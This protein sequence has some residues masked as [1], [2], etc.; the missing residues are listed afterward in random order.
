MNPLDMAMTVLKASVQRRVSQDTPGWAT[1]LIHEEGQDP[2]V[3]WS[4]TAHPSISD[5]RLHGAQ[6][7]AGYAPV[8]E[9]SST[10][11]RKPTATTD[12]DS[13]DMASDFQSKTRNPAKNSLLTRLKQIPKRA[14]QD[15][16]VQERNRM[17]WADANRQNQQA[18][19]QGT[20]QPVPQP[21]PLQQPVPQP[22]PLQQ[23]VPQPQGMVNQP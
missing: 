5:E 8:I 7:S 1:Q 21:P 16:Q 12:D 17:S 2:D 13:Y 20:M 4:K 19:A 9:S 11:I 6:L 10:G 18:L 3:K 23:P 22:P 14:A 15:M